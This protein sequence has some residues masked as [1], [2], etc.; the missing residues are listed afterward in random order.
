MWNDAGM[1]KGGEDSPGAREEDL[2]QV[3]DDSQAQ[4][5][6]DQLGGW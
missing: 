3:C 4:D 6:L 2:G 1:F 5:A